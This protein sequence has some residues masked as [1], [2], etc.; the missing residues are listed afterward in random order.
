[1]N[2]FEILPSIRRLFIDTAPVIYF[3]EQNSQYLAVVR[4]VFEAISDSTIAAIVSPVT[5]AECLVRPY[6][7]Q[8]TQY[9]TIFINLSPV[10]QELNVSLSV[11]TSLLKLLDSA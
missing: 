11:K 9:P 5:L 4:P 3:V 2:L 7:L 1:M 8:Q 10:V 6:E